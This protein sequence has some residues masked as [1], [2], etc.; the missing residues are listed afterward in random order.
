MTA[1]IGRS[2]LYA[3]GDR[4]DRF[5]KALAS[6]AH[7]VILD[8]EDGVAPSAKE[9][10]RENVKSFIANNNQTGRLWVRIDPLTMDEDLPVALVPGV[11]GVFLAKADA[12][13][14]QRT[15][16]AL[17]RSGRSTVGIV[18]LIESASSLADAV[19]IARMDGVTTLAV[20]F[21]DLLADLRVS[22][23]AP[24]PVLDS[25]L[26]RIVI[27]AAAANKSAP[28]APTSTAIRDAEALVESGRSLRALGFRSRTAIHPVQVPVINDVFGPQPDEIARARDL[29]ET[30][31]ASGV[32]V[33]ADGS[34]ID[35]A[36][37]RSARETLASID[38]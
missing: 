10:A 35:A 33:G 16:D 8:L 12:D 9:S 14:V 13:N 31:G 21:V 25:L 17:V 29:I 6:S 3:P 27:A 4:P 18:P 30:L 34:M 11:S 37:I 32:A 38:H 23:E 28:I 1:V 2:F 26:L 22:R 24:A 19:R 5:E 20:G 15:R 36:V 7:A